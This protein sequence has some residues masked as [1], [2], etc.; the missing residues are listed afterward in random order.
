MT[1][2][3]LDRLRVEILGPT[4]GF[5]LGRSNV[6]TYVGGGELAWLP[7]DAPLV[8]ADPTAIASGGPLGRSP[9]VGSM[10][11]VL[12]EHDG[13]ALRADLNLRANVPVRVAHDGVPLW[14]GRILDVY[15]T[16]SS[17]GSTLTTILCVDPVSSYA[18]TTRVGATSAAGRE[19]FTQRVERVT[20]NTDVVLDPPPPMPTWTLSGS[21]DDRNVLGRWTGYGMP[22]GNVHH[23]DFH[24]TD[25]WIASGTIATEGIALIV[26]FQSVSPP[27]SS[28]SIPA[29]TVGAQTTIT[30]LVPGRRYRVTGLGSANQSLVVGV[31]GLGWGP[32]GAFVD[33]Y[34]TPIAP[35]DFTATYSAHTVRV[36]YPTPEAAPDPE[37]GAWGFAVTRLTLTEI[38]PADDY[39]ERDIG[40]E[41]SVA[42]HLDI[43][44]HTADAYWWPTRDGRVRART[45]LDTTVRA[46]LSDLA[47]PSYADPLGGRDTRRVVNDWRVTNLGRDPATGN[48]ADDTHLVDDDESVATYGRRSKAIELSL[49]TGDDETLLAQR[50]DQIAASQATADDTL[51]SIT[52]RPSDDP[53]LITL[54][55]N[56]LITVTRDGSTHSVRVAAIRHA[57]TARSWT[58]VL[59]LR[60]EN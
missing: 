49:H 2:P 10:T 46:A 15:D 6:G 11:V 4:S 12:G 14:T 53:S 28:W 26:D 35:Y 57:I 5:V 16:T 60:K 27:P 37:T 32:V 50:L 18:N 55:L 7:Y 1:P 13:N 22:S 9:D 59:D 58:A 45:I 51:T 38:T 25:Q 34:E 24:R 33:N 41:A 36:A 43:A 23:V 17:K 31:D 52:I 44:A 30:G 54:E 56:D 19:H 48:S 8:S 21:P 3:H 42:T 39:L 40:R 20:E 47:D 29:K